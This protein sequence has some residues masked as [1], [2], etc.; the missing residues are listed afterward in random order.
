MHA[1]PHH[2]HVV[3]APSAHAISHAAPESSTVTRV[4]LAKARAAGPA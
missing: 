3:V 2:A 4:P 1:A